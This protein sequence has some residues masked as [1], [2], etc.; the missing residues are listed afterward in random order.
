MYP[1][2]MVIPMREEL[3]RLGLQELRTAEEV[4]QA[5]KARQ[6]TTLVVVNSVCGCVR[7]FAW[8]CRTRLVLTVPSPCL[9]DKTL[10]PR[11]APGVT[12]PDNRRLRRL[13]PFFATANS[14]T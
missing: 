3:T 10:K 13:L 4:D 6:G 5:L 14:S 1:E 12:S 2:I 8:H 9:Q 7:L 11:N